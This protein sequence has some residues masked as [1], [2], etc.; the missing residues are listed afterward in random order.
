ML[1][2]HAGIADRRMWDGQVPVLSGRYHVIRYDQRG[3]GESAPP[4][5][6]YCPAADVG[7]VLGHAD[8]DWAVLVGCSIGG[9]IAIS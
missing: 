8:A 2:A 9:A 4:E 7:A 6:P 3:F 5:A 1:L